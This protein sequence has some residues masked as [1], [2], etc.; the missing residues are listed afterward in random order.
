MAHLGV[1]HFGSTSQG[2]PREGAE[3][4]QYHAASAE[5]WVM[6]LCNAAV[7]SAAL[8]VRWGVRIKRFKFKL[9]E[10]FQ[11]RVIFVSHLVGQHPFFAF[12]AEFRAPLSSYWTIKFSHALSTS[13]SY[14]MN[15][16]WLTVR[17]LWQINIS[18]TSM[19][20]SLY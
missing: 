19:L 5:V 12:N 17:W 8:F 16:I 9:F 3:V 1:H 13:G 2:L 20:S 7:E 18:M 11:F 6:S 4:L 14:A 15:H 10:S